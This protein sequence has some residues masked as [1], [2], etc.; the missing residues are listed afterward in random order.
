M[1]LNAGVYVNSDRY[2]DCVTYCNKI[3]DAGFTLHPNYQGLFL[4]DNNLSP[5]IIFPIA[6]DGNFETLNV[7]KMLGF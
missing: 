4:A 6:C 1:Y 2:G 3:L 7:H 5:E